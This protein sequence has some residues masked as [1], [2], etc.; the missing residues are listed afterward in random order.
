MLALLATVNILV[1]K[2]TTG[3]LAHKPG[4]AVASFTGCFSEQY[5]VLGSSAYDFYTPSLK[6]KD[7][8]HYLKL[9]KKIISYKIL[10][11]NTQ[12]ETENPR[13]WG[14]VEAL[15]FCPLAWKNLKSSITCQKR[16]LVSMT[17]FPLLILPQLEGAA[18]QMPTLST[19]KGEWV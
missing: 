16:V 5:H 9:E 17:L 2:T 10:S 3:I 6:K 11:V 7:Q 1:F 12:R 18:S 14:E 13:E 15:A 8:I 4:E 19:D